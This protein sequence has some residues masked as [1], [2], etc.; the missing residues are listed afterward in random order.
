MTITVGTDLEPLVAALKETR[1]GEIAVRDVKIDDLRPD[2]RSRVV[3]CLTP[4]EP[5]RRWNLD[6]FYTVRVRVR[7]LISSSLLG[8][9]AWITT[10]DGD[11]SARMERPVRGTKALIRPSRR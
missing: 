10:S 6:D 4:P 7:D 11:P 1:A 9:D 3:V 2:S 5:G 8:D